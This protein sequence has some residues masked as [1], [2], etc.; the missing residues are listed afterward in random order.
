LLRRL[1]ILLRQ[2]N[3]PALSVP[4]RRLLLAEL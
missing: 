1:Q 2:L 3:Q 4:L